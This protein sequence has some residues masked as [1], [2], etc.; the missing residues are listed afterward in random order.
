MN[1][2]LREKWRA[3]R[4]LMW[5]GGRTF[6]ADYTSAARR[7]EYALAYVG[8]NVEL[9]LESSMDKLLIT[10]EAYIELLSAAW[11][12]ATGLDPKN[13]ELVQQQTATG[14]TFYFRERKP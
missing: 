13:A 10:Q 3:I 1:N 6:G 4:G 12:K 8:S 11:L 9:G 14:F 2:W 7:L 5:H